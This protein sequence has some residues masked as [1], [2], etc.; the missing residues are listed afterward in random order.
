MND[1]HLEEVEVMTSPLRALKDGVKF[2]P[3]L[4]C[5]AEQVSGILLNRDKLQEFLQ[6]VLRS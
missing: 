1:V 2:I 3:T 6:R 5:G 4:K